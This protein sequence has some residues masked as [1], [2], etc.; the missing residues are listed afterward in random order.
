MMDAMGMSETY[1]EYFHYSGR[2]QIDGS[3]TSDLKNMVTEND[4]DLRKNIC[5]QL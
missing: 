1:I 4:Y 3:I 2:N 5:D